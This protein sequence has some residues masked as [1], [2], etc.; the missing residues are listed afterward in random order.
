MN[1]AGRIETTELAR[2]ILSL[3]GLD[4]AAMVE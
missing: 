2:V 1:L 4:T 3:G